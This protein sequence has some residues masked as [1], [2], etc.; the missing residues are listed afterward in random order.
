M[1]EISTGHSNNSEPSLALGFLFMHVN[2]QL[3]RWANAC[4]M[5]VPGSD[6]AACTLLRDRWQ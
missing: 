3:M 5:T 4:H 6:P 2:A 1:P